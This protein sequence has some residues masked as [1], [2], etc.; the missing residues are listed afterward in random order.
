[1]GVKRKI[2]KSADADEMLLTDAFEHFI[3]EKEALGKS[4]ATL[5]SYRGSFG[6]FNKLVCTED[7]LCKDIDSNRI[8]RWINIMKQDDIKVASINHYLRDIRTFLNWCMDAKREFITEPFKINMVD[9]QEESIKLFTDDEIHILL[10]APH[11]TADFAEYRMWVIIQWVLAT[12]NRASTICNIKMQDIDFKVKEV[13][14]KHTKNKKATKAIP[15]SSEIISVIKEYI[16][17]FR[18]TAA[19]EDYLFANVGD[20]Q[21]STNA[22]RLSLERYCKSRG[23]FKEGLNKHGER[24]GKSNIHGLRH[25]YAK[26]YVLSNGSMFKLQQMLGHSTLD[27]TRKYVNLFNQ[28]LH[29]EHDAHT[30]L[31]NF[32]KGKSRRKQIYNTDKV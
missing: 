30:P 8:Y 16:R 10:E 19:P 27:M 23:V 9:G 32:K 20:E 1:M 5:R 31:D 6:Q 17:K 14:L 2:K 7:D 28:D 15:L 11:R 4:P 13:Q 24:I 21:L 3:N 12:G 22:L 29:H 25:N 18:K 26:G